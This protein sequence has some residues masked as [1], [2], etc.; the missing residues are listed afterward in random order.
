MYE[1]TKASVQDLFGQ[2]FFCVEIKIEK[3]EK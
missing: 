1:K 3:N 2:T